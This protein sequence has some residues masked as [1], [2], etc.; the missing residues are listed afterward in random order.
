MGTEKDDNEKSRGKADPCH[1][2]F[3]V[4]SCKKKKEKNSAKIIFYIHIYILSCV[5]S[6][7]L[8]RFAADNTTTRRRLREQLSHSLSPLHCALHSPA[9]A[10]SRDARNTSFSRTSAPK[11]NTRSYLHECV[12]VH[13]HKGRLFC[14]DHEHDFLKKI[15]YKLGPRLKHK[16]NRIYKR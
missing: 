14:R 10:P 15:R 12:C 1:R 2:L 4:F 13:S 6:V 7:F 8:D 9:A 5:A 16:T 11:H 3:L